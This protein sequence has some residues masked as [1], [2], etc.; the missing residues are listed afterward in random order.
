M[1]ASLRILTVCFLICQF[2]GSIRA[3]C[4]LV[5]GSTVHLFWDANS[6]LDLDDAG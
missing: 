6:E 1:P 4:E 5:T 3:Q 2:W